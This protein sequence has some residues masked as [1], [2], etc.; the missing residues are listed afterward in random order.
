MQQQFTVGQIVTFKIPTVG[1]STKV[2]GTIKRITDGGFGADHFE[3]KTQQHGYYVISGDDVWCEECC[4]RNADCFC[5]EQKWT[6]ETARMQPGI[7][8]G[9]R[10]ARNQ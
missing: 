8:G 6:P 5:P 7:R 4:H 3:V 1:G 10:S 9:C 2:A